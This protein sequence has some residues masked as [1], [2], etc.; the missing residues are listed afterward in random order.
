MN[1]SQNLGK[2]LH[3]EEMVGGSGFEPPTTRPDQIPAYLDLVE[4]C[5]LYDIELLPAVPGRLLPSVEFGG[6]ECRIFT[7]IY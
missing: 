5:C 1:L 4:I 6:L 3:L 2:K 7:H